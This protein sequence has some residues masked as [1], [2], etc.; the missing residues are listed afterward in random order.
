M[1]ASKL[2]QFSFELIKAFGEHIVY[3]KAFNE[4]Q[5]MI[6]QSIN[7]IEEYKARKQLISVY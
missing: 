6:E 5:V 1:V 2:Q 7:K 4:R 3:S